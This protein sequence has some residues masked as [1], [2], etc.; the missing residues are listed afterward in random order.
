MKKGKILTIQ[1]FLVCPV[2]SKP[3]QRELKMDVGESAHAANPSGQ[4][5]HL[6]RER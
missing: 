5:K 1:M 4:I 6:E 2:L 3:P